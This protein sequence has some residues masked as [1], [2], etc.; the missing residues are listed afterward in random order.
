MLVTMMTIGEFAAM[1]GISVK[2][3]RH[4]DAEQVLVP[5]EVD[6]RSGYRRYA[7]DQVR[8]GVQ[9]KALRDADVGL[10]AASSAISTGSAVAALRR[11]REELARERQQQDHA[12]DRAGQVLAALEVATT[13]TIATAGTRHWVGWRICGSLE[14]VDGLDETAAN[15]AFG[16]LHQRATA[17]GLEPTGEFWTTLR[18]SSRD[19]VEILLCWA[20]GLPAGA[21]W[22]GPEV[23]AGTLPRRR[24]LTARWAG[25]AEQLPEDATHPAVVALFDAIASRGLDLADQEIRQGPEG[26]DP[27]APVRV[28]VTLSD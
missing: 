13:V 7:E 28:S 5:A 9:L 20:T 27:T 18:A 15:G 11:H 17:A 3:L 21:G 14:E 25:D 6:P 8:F 12:L 19:Q 26:T 1:T 22:V 4:Y 24:E 23:V 10:A 2:A 16:E